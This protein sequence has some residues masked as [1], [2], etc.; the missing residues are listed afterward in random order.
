[1]SRHMLD[2]HSVNPVINPSQFEGYETWCVSQL[3]AK[4]RMAPHHHDD[5]GHTSSGLTE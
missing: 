1:V 2:N 5:I 4:S 3:S